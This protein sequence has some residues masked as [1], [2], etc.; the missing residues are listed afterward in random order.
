MYRLFQKS[1]AV[2][3]L[4]QATLSTSF[5]AADDAKELTI[6][7]TA[8]ALN[9][10]HW[11]QDGG[12]KFKPVTKFQD[13]KVYVVEFWATWC[14][15]CRA[16]MPHLVEVQKKYAD[17]GVQIISISDEDLETVQDFLK[18]K[19][20]APKGAPKDSVKDMTYSELTSAYCLTTDPDGSSS[21][22]YL[23]AASQN[24]IPAAFIVGKS[25][26]IE[27]IGHP[28]EMDEPLEK[29]LAGTWDRNAF[30]EKFQEEQALQK[31]MMKFSSLMQKG[32]TEDGL[33]LLEDLIKKVK[34]SSIRS[35]L[36]SIRFQI[37]MQDD[38][39]ATK[40]PEAAKDAFASAKGNAMATN[41]IAWFLFEG[42]SN[43]LTENKELLKLALAASQAE[44]DKAAKDFKASMMDTIA[45]LHDELGDVAK[46]LE[47]QKAAIAIATDEEKANLQKYL[48]EL[49]TKLEQAKPGK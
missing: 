12:G 2:A 10:E 43:G 29:V 42:Y 1:L 35:Q 25:Q 38:K 47:V 48:D 22:D 32:K 39:L 26:K 30:A 41:E 36:T 5:L 11:L 34:D 8:P 27:W 45:H 6:G 7:S 24:G 31:A 3:V 37:L 4:C 21:K 19:V 13:G 18:S 46:A 49:K 17:Q 33:A 23:E 16:S 28:M 20:P 14:G 40:L 15:P 44:V 9:V